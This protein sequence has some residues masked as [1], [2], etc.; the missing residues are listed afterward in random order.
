[1]KKTIKTYGFLMV[2]L[3]ASLLVWGFTI[4]YNV[5]PIRTFTPGAIWPDT[6]GKHINA[7]GGGIL[8][9]NGVYYWFGEHRSEG[10]KGFATYV[11]VGCYS[12]TDLLNWDNRGI[13]LEVV[14]DTASEITKGC[15]IERPKVVYN[16]KTQQFV[17]WFHLE[18]KGRSYEAAKTGVAVSQTAEGPYR[19]VGSFRPN[20]GVWPMGYNGKRE[21]VDEVSNYKWWTPEWYQAVDEG[22]FVKRDFEAGQMSRDM[23]VF[24]DDDGRA[25]HIRSSEENLTLHIAELS[26]DYLSFTDRWIRVF[27]A[28]HNEAPAV[29]KHKNKYYMVASGCTGWDANAARLAVADSMLG[30]WTMLGN[31]CVGPNADKTFFSQSTFVLPVN[32]GFVFMADRWTP[33]NLAEAPYVWL[34]I[35]FENDKPT[36]NWS[37]SWSLDELR[38]QLKN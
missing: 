10:R 15:I 13:A 33:K 9:H 7:H 17:M 4:F 37:E 36:I 11:G 29:F 5:E 3:T 38:I 28:G 34:P 2:L 16:D 6:D 18:L 23:T 24:K 26:S 30:H 20:A 12:S 25:Y 1:M 31:P 14:D 19:F 35:K 22:L 27:P 21:A 8:Q 32:N